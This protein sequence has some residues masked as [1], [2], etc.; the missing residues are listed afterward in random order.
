MNTRFGLGRSGNASRRMTALCVVA[1]ATSWQC[2]SFEEPELPDLSALEETYQH[3][4]GRIAE[5]DLARVM[6]QAAQTYAMYQENGS[7]DLMV[8]KVKTAI[9]EIVSTSHP[10]ENSRFKLSATARVQASCTQQPQT[11]ELGT[12]ELELA[13]ERNFLQPGVSGAF[14][15]CAAPDLSSVMDGPVELY[16]ARASPLKAP[17]LTTILVQF[18]G[19]ARDTEGKSVRGPVHFRILDDPMIEVGVVAD[20]GI[21]VVGYLPSGGVQLR[22]GEGSF[23]CDLERRECLALTG[24]SCEELVPGD[25][26]WSW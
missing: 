23:C 6:D 8:A 10:S 26:I 1:S 17:D 15:S 13:V 5:I 2:A 14:R 22:T 25:E 11:G 4:S 20:S 19:V 12:I 16:L 7:F 3:P 18:D 21:V 24:S 9:S